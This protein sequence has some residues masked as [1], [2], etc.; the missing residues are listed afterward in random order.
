MNSQ[1]NTSVDLYKHLGHLFYAIIAIDKRIKN[2][3]LEMLE[4]III[5]RWLPITTK[6]PEI[7]ILKTIKSTIDNLIKEKAD[8]NLAFENFMKYK[9]KNELLFSKNTKQ[10]ILKTASMIANASSGHN[11]SELILLAKLDLNF[12][13]KHH[14]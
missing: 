7:D 3:E 2:V 4:D 12:R 9:T 8:A 10:L 6:P 14:N 11:K 5:S 13:K 1:K